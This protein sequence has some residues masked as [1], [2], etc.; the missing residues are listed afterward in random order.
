MERLTL[1][2]ITDIIFRL[3]K[4]QSERAIAR[5]LNYHRVTIPRPKPARPYLF[6]ASQQAGNLGREQMQRLPDERFG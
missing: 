3:R 2:E 4:G 6:V 1:R 5:D